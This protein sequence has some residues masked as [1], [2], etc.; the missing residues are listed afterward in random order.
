MSENSS[1]AL[2]A[3][4]AQNTIALTAD[5][6]LDVR[7]RVKVGEAAVES[8]VA[9]CRCG[10]SRNKPYCDNSHKD[11]GFRHGGALAP[12]GEPST[13][14]AAEG[15]DLIVEPVKN[16]PLHCTGSVVIVG[17]DGARV[18]TDKTWLCRCGGSARKPFCDGTHRRI[19]FAT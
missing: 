6:P 16:G 14:A 12:A 8:C 17:T 3:A 10:T 2:R 13:G 15:V 11:A 9:L 19:G 18:V 5:G 1:E 7:G 4:D